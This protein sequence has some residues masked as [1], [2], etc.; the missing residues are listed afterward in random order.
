MT[1]RRGPSARPSGTGTAG[2][3]RASRQ[4]DFGGAPPSH[5]PPSLLPWMPA[6]PS[7]YMTSTRNAKQPTQKKTSPTAPSPESRLSSQQTHQH[8]HT[9]SG[10]T[11][12]RTE[13]G[14]RAGGGRLLGWEMQLI[15]L[16]SFTRLKSLDVSFN[17][18]RSMAAVAGL[19]AAQPSHLFFA[20]NKITAIEGLAGL[21]G[22]TSLELGSNRLRSM[23]GLSTLVALQELYVGRNKLTTLSGLSGLTQLR[24]LSIQSNRITKMEGLETCVALEEL[25]LSHN[26]IEVMEGLDT[27]VQLNTLDITANRLMR[28]QGLDCNTRSVPP[29]APPCPSLPLATL[30]LSLRRRDCGV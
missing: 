1:C 30:S 8:H 4:P 28:V 10:A 6:A 3:A 7:V 27:L 22:L 23:E 19:A 17:S 14:G 20:A 13:G 11:L 18:V 5:D 16:E 29:S 2:G 21:T 15:G 24:I 9:K 12:L 26:G 25:Y